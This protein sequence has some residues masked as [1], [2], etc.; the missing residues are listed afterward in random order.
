MNAPEAI[1]PEP[2]RRDPLLALREA[3]ASQHAVL[4]AALAIG[5][6][7]ADA[8]TYAAH[9]LVLRRWLA[10]LESWLP[11]F[12]DGPFGPGGL[13]FQA[14]MPRIHADLDEL[15]ACGLAAQAVA[16]CGLAVENGRPDA[17]AETRLDQWSAPATAAYRWGVAYV[18]EG[19]QLGGAVLYQQLKTRL[20]PLSLCY[21]RGDVAGPG[22]RWRDFMLGLRSQVREAEDIEE[23]CRG[24]RDVFA[25]FSRTACADALTDTAP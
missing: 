7:G 25:W 9:L 22:P 13:S 2:V 6:P 20:A 16:P 17:P 11:A 4:D 3:T 14:R 21:L 1:G 19:S 5:R 10:P 15:H 12:P 23:A 8:Q 24:A 18:M